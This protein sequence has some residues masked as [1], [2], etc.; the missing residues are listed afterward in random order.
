[1]VCHA[2]LQGIFP[3]Q[4]WNHVSCGSRIAVGLFIAKPLGKA[5]V[6]NWESEL[7][8]A[9]EVKVAQSCLTLCDPKDY[10]VH[11]ILQA[12]IL[13][14]VAVPFSRGSAQLWSNSNLPHCRWILYQLSHQGSPKNA[15]EHIIVW[16]SRDDVGFILPGLLRGLVKCLSFIFQVYGRK[17][18]PSL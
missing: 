15:V 11:R 13:E 6:G 3:T 18:G 4:G 5:N 7:K 2:L 17:F 8:N 12:R 10:T 16:L 14:W 9:V 1:M